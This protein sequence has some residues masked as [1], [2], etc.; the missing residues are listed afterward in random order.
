[1]KRKFALLFSLIMLWLC[2]IS[3]FA[4]PVVLPTDVP[5]ASGGCTLLGIE[6]KY[7]VQIQQALDRINEIRYEA[8]QEGVYKPSAYGTP[9]RPLTMSDYVPIKWSS[10]LEYIARIRAAEASLTM[11]H[12]RTNGDS[13]FALYSPNYAQSFGEV[14][15][16]NW[17]E[18]M[19]QGINQWYGEKTDWV[20]QTSGAVTGHYT[21]MIDPDN[22]Y[23]GLA[24]FC[25]DTAQY[26]NTT[27]GEFASYSYMDETHGPAIESCI[28][29]VEVYNQ[30][31]NNRYTIAG[32]ASSKRGEPVSLQLTTGMSIR[33]YWGSTLTTNG[34]L[35]LDPVTWSSSDPSVATVDANGIVMPI[36]CGTTQ[37]TA[38]GTNGS[39]ATIPF[40]VNHT[41]V[42]D[43]AVAATCTKTGLTQG[44]HCSVCGTVLTAQ[45]TV[46][47]TPHKWNNGTITKEATLK[48][49]GQKTYSCQLCGTTR[50]ETIP[51]L[52]IAKGKT[53]VVNNLKY[54]ITN[55]K[56]NGKGT[57]AVVGTTTKKTS[58]KTLKIGD[59]VSF[60]GVKFLVTEISAK[61]FKSC[62]KLQTVAIGKNISVIGKEAFMNCK[63][64]K[65]M[66][67]SS[68]KLKTVGANAVKS[69]YSKAAIKVPSSKVSAYKKL[70]KS[71]TG[72]KT[73]MKITK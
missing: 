69:I 22:R 13:C 5:T 8:C 44:K 28:Q 12:V 14:L 29:T 59:T 67:I 40:T 63:K 62:T 27:A 6:G 60:G 33:D 57:V 32:T 15:A 58:L 34:L 35:V 42:I 43:Q 46:P 20:K 39:G 51:K 55:A 23:V 41:E 3:V 26:Y 10:D 68:K 18:T 47:L 49:A 4:A 70:F 16:W 25:T 64:L 48:E 36:K 65:K 11:D 1:M 2:S 17:S 66:T 9:S 30:F 52:K 37:I 53:F 72:F 45:R 61:S 38:R 54:K 19:T 71:S 50:T 21:A 7:I 73:T 56:T 31:L 24:T